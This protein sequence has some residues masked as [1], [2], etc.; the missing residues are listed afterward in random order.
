MNSEKLFAVVV[1]WHNFQQ[2]ESFL[3]SWGISKWENNDAAELR[4]SIP[5]WL[6][7][8]RDTN[9]S[10]CAATKNRG[11]QGAID[12]GYEN[13]IVLDD[14]CFRLPEVESLES[15]AL[16]HVA[17]LH[18]VEVD[19]FDQITEPRSRGTPFF[20]RSIKMPVAA[21]LGFWRNIG[22]Y[23]APGQLIHGATHPM[24][25][26]RTPIFGRYFAFSGMN[27]AFHRDWWPVAKQIEIPRYDDIWM[28]L[29][30][31][32]IA[33]A[34]GA[35]FNFAAPDV[36]HSR[37]SNVFQNLRDEAIYAEENETLWQRIHEHPNANY[38]ELT[39]LLPKKK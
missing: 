34:R 6:Y 20:K 25:F 35:C 28:G 26:R 11:I 39:S 13:I 38:H 23:D 19:L 22:D 12:D 29:I 27:Y 14:D 4:Y 7:L 37:Q 30:W 17:A 8:Q 16:A 9:R 18:P 21:S 31:Q 15:F 24:N 33:Y 10:G 3:D 2:C 36:M 1:A 5:P 32:K